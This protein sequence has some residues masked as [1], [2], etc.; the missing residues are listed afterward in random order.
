M[1]ILLS[2]AKVNIGLWIE[3]RRED[4]YHDIFSFFHTVDFYDKIVITPY[5][6]LRVRCSL[7]EEDLQEDRNIVYKAVV[8]FETY[9]GIQQNWDILIEKN[10]PVG[11]GLGGGSS[12]AATVL[13]FLNQ[14]YNKPLNEEELFKLAT[15]LGSDVPFFLKGGFA[16]AEGV[17]EKLTF[18]DETLSEEI[19]I[20]YPNVKSYTG[21]VYSNVSQNILTNKDQLNIILNLINEYG[22][23]KIFEVAEN[24]LGE[25]AKKIY[26]EIEEVYHFLEYT[27]Y[28][29]Y[30]TGSGSSVYCIG[31]PSKEVETACKVRNWKLI[32]TRFK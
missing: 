28:K 11:G 13:K 2:P 7:P 23:K 4:G 17:G 8:L 20:I 25:I 24:K 1:K 9:T 31:T 29:P 21:K 5:H 16:L 19:F 15:K 12:N 30:I 26:P 10:I 22:V 27:G 18:F 3:K 14:H 6:S 32:K